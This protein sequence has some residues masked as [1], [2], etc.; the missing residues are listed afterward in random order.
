MN[1]EKLR[2]AADIAS[3]NAIFD[4]HPWNVYRDGFIAGVEWL[5]QQ[6][7]SDR[8]IEEEKARIKEIYSV[9]QE[10]EMD[11]NPYRPASYVDEAIAKMCLLDDIFGQELFNKK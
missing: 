7:L 8:L 10:V 4:S 9:Y 1:K 5:M 11:D 6:P 3:D 2:D